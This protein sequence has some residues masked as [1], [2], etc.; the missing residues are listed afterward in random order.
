MS[1][2]SLVCGGHVN[3]EGFNDPLLPHL[4]AAIERTGK[5]S[6]ID[7][8]VSFIRQSGLVLLRKALHNALS[9]GAHLRVITSD[10]LDVTEP[11][12]LRELLKF[13]SNCTT[14]LI[15]QSQGNRGFHL[16]SY[17][18]IQHNEDAKISGQAFVGSSNV[19]AAALTDSLEWNWS[20]TS[21]AGS[22]MDGVQHSL[23][24]LH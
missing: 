12:A 7:L 21:T 3:D 16:K 11:V 5:G 24:Q 18:F 20:L 17:L 23:E 14:A 8:C 13:D 22:P 10:Y 4:L 9:R 1:A 2:L 6:H 15:Y 19:S